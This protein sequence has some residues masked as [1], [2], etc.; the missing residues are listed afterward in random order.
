MNDNNENILH[1]YC[2][3]KRCK[4]SGSLHGTEDGSVQEIIEIFAEF[5]PHAFT[6]RTK[7]ER[8]TPLHYAMR[9]G[10]I[11]KAK[12]ILE[13]FTGKSQKSGFKPLLANSETS[14]TG[15]S[16]LANLFNLVD[17]NGM[18]AIDLL[19]IR[20]DTEHKKYEVNLTF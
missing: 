10:N 13:I 9:S 6:Q 15:N 20:Q 1:I 7:L 12:C 8:Q 11:Q 3:D 4:R 5:A 17:Y 2:K 14:L 19:A 18:R 16:A